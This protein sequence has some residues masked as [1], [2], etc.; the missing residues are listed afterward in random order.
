MVVQTK[1]VY[2]ENIPF[3]HTEQDV[4]NI[5]STVGPVLGVKIAFDQLTGKS[6][7]YAFIEYSDSAT[8]SSAVRNLNNYQV[9]SRVLKCGY[10]AG[11][12]LNGNVRIINADGTFRDEQD[13]GETEAVSIFK[14][15]PGEENQRKKRKFDQG[16][17]PLPHG[18]DVPQGDSALNVISARIRAMDQAQL[19][20]LLNDGKEMAKRNPEL[21]EEL[22][23][24]CPQLSS[25]LVEAL[26]VLRLKTPADVREL[27]D[28][29]EDEEEE[30]EEVKPELDADQIAAIKQVIALLP[31]EVAQV[32]AEQRQAIVDIQE[33]YKKGIYGKI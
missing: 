29:D 2:L 33:N 4:Q 22:L 6:K 5:A 20:K 19:E 11:S 17:P 14:S 23:D 10:G 24:R 27:V 3:E 15:G 18:V 26:V 28:K 9:G 7:G 13:L 8:A 1:I 25:A 12:S 31:E 32:P 16:I 21:M 30:E